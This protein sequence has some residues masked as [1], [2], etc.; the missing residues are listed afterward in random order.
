M[1]GII[2]PTTAIVVSI[3]SHRVLVEKAS[4]MEVFLE[5]IEEARL[6]KVAKKRI[7]NLIPEIAIDFENFVKE[8]GFD[9]DE[10]I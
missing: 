4:K 3:N 5:K 8:Q 2:I 7:K 9:I 6:L 1:L 10:I